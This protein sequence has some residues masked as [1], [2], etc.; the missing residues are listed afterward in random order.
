MTTH[1]HIRTSVAAALALAATLILSTASALAGPAKQ[2]G[3]SYPWPVKPFGQP[4][5]VRGSFGDPRTL[6]HGPPTARTLLSG[7]GS[8]TFHTG[9]DISAPD[10]S[11]VY[12]VESGTVRS[13]SH[14]WISVDSGNGRAFQYWHITSTVAVGDHVEAQT[15]VLGHIIRGCQ[16]VHLTELDGGVIVNP[17][18]AGHLSPYSDTT[19]P[20][21]MGISI[22][23]TVTGRD[24]MPELLRGRV[25]LL[26][27]VADAPTLKVPAPWTDMPVTPALVSWQIRRADSGKVVVPAH[28][29]YDVRDHLP[30]P[31]AFWRV[32]ARGTHQNMSVFGKHY[33]YMQPGLFLLRLT[34]GGF[35]TRQLADAVY[36]LVVTATDI[37]GNHSSTVQR[38]SVH[39]RPGVT[40]V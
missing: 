27:A 20:S 39:N 15:T 32:Y 12:P 30:A 8:F 35:D 36:E 5:P 6:F 29:A 19:V 22:R 17:L 31:T 40:G 4:H 33:S 37:R 3:A 10:G 13:V 1:T 9:V 2:A 7:G 16:H 14:D 28:T 23:T 11:P 34:P 25:E 38:F 26:A 21:V 18:A 24:L